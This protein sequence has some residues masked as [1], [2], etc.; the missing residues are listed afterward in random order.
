MIFFK[1]EDLVLDLL[2]LLT[3]ESNEELKKSREEKY[4]KITRPIKVERENVLSFD[5]VP[6]SIDESYD[7]ELNKNTKYLNM[8]LWTNQFTGKMTKVKSLLIGYVSF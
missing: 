2:S 7:F 6:I 1:G 3:N 8:F 5:N 4:Y